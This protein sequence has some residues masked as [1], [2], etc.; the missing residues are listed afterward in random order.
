[1]SKLSLALI[2]TLAAVSLAAAVTAACDDPPSRVTTNIQ[3]LYDARTNLCFA[4]KYGG[5]SA[6]SFTMAVIP[7]SPEIMTLTGAPK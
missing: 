3:Y 1:M 2:C 4:T 6:D 5:V 7:C